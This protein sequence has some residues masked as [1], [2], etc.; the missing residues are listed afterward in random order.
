MSILQRRELVALR[1]H[2]Q[3][4]AVAAMLDATSL[5]RQPDLAPSLQALTL[6]FGYLCGE[7]DTKFSALA[8]Q[9]GLPYFLVPDAGHNAHRAEPA[10]FAG[11]L[12]SLLAPFY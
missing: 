5:A 12:L 4:T 3:G 1:I 9:A 8:R 10:A 6:P 11:Q 2:N 7:R